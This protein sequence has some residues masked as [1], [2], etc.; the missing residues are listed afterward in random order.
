[1]ALT[2]TQFGQKIKQK[3]PEYNDL[4]D[5]EVGSKMLIKYPEYQ[6]MVDEG[7]TSTGAEKFFRP[8]MRGVE[9]ELVPFSEKTGQKLIPGDFSEQAGEQGLV[10]KLGY[11]TGFLLGSLPSFALTGGIAK[12]ITALPKVANLVTKLGKGKKVAQFLGKN[13]KNLTQMALLGASQETE[14]PA[15]SAKG[16][17]E[18]AGNIGSYTAT[19]AAFDLASPYVAKG[20]RNL[21]GKAPKEGA[22][23]AADTAATGEKKLAGLL[24]PGEKKTLITP[25]PGTVPKT[26][27]YTVSPQYATE[28]PF[29]IS[30]TS[31]PGSVIQQMKNKTVQETEKVIDGEIS[32]TD[33]KDIFKSVTKA[34]V[35]DEIAP[36]M[37]GDKYASSINLDRFNI[38][39]KQK[40]VLRKN[41]NLFQ[42]ELTEL[43]GKPITNKELLDAVQQS[44]VLT[45][46]ATRDEQ[47]KFNAGLVKLRQTIASGGKEVGVSKEYLENLKTLNSLA[48]EWGRRGRAFAL[49]VDASEGRMKEQVLKQ[50]QQL[51]TKT[52]DVLKAA[53]GLDWDNPKQV[54]EFYRKFVKATG[55]EKLTEWRY[56]SMLSSPNTHEINAFTNLLQATVVDPGTKLFSGI[57]DSIGSRL[58]GKARQHYVSEVPAYYRGMFNSWGDAAKAFGRVM[59]Q[60]AFVERPDIAFM[61]TNDWKTKPMMPILRAL[62]ASDAFFRTLIAGGEKEAIA[63]S[64]LKRGVKLSKDEIE[65]EALTR[66][67]YFVFRETGQ[68]AAIKQGANKWNPLNMI[69]KATESLSST[70]RDYP[71][72][73][74]IVPFIR[75]PMNILKQGIEY[76]PLGFS[77]IAGSKNVTEQT[78][79]AVMGSTITMLS[80]MAAF[81]GDSTWSAPTSA[82]AKEKFF[83]SGRQ[84]FSLKV[85][86]RW[87][88][89]QRLGPLAYPIALAAAV[90]YYAQQDPKRFT[91]SGGKKAVLVLQSYLQFF[92]QQSYV[93]SLGNLIDGIRGDTNSWEKL[94][95]NLPRQVIPLNSLQSWVARI[96]DPIYRH[97]GVNST[98]FLEKLGEQLA[99]TTPGF[100]QNIEP[101]TD[102]IGRPSERQSPLFN[103]LSP[104]RVTKEDP[105]FDLLY[106]IGQ[107][108][109]ADTNVK[110]T[111]DKIV[112]SNNTEDVKIEK[113]RKLLQK[114]QSK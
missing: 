51:G 80:A 40:E 32:K 63:L 48:S 36:S 23:L 47:L 22:T 114:Y 55:W 30:E 60:E 90:K 111:I 13:A 14:D 70:G 100:S 33:M 59:K 54:T 72:L 37:A 43:K 2:L 64:A 104:M 102:P 56:I 50:L 11:G 99:S 109:S 81:M 95:A 65:K 75:T 105:I 20:F 73:R 96:I 94:V 42:K 83:A 26:S 62:E 66:A 4:S 34:I 91:N 106:Q 93:D 97:P 78:A 110:N 77:T 107:D 57:V 92:S 39:A 46:I 89:F 79:K 6:D 10:S 19:G 76:S 12:G 82:S 103:A 27:T 17:A 88:S 29:I 24:G 68:E 85:G 41:I 67:K 98:G 49:P 84:P 86:D 113:I 44:E 61:P 45:H 15:L 53:E 16:L 31:S 7:A 87:V 18:R 58:T 74:W 25:E 21:F 71:P 9:N 8:L 112:A 5:E 1:M 3:H 69:D 101:Y 108:K 35:P 52:D 38:S 28:K